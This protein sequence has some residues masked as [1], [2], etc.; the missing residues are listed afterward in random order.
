VSAEVRPGRRNLTAAEA[1]RRSRTENRVWMK[2]GNAPE[3]TLLHVIV[4]SCIIGIR[5]L[6]KVAGKTT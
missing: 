2:R 3:V 6:T 4:L 1:I 5:R